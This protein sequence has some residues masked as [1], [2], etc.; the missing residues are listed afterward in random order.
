[1]LSEIRIPAD[2]RVGCLFDSWYL[3]S[4]II[5]IITNKRWHWYSRCRS[6][7]KVR[8]QGEKRAWNKTEQVR[9]YAKTID[10][11]NLKYHSSRKHRA[12]VG[13]Q[14]I[15]E[16]KNLG[17]LKMVFTSLVESG[18]ERIAYFC[19][20]D[21]SIQLIELVKLFELRWKIEIYFR[22]SR[23]FF[24]LEKWYCRNVAS[25]VHH[26][27]LSMLAAVA[28]AWVRMH[29]CE[30]NESFGSLGEFI[31]SCRK[32]NQRELLGIF[33]ER[34]DLEN[35]HSKNSNKFIALCEE[36]GL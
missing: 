22:E 28:C 9:E 4:T 5:E 34:C 13:H 36:M 1:M 14:R 32:R 8:W 20:N 19:T 21:T 31:E 15:G 17:R 7:R 35:I 11:Q 30:K 26:L 12:V 27:C 24:A 6:N 18:S 2:Y 3:N 10:W 29:E 16:L 25:V 33:I 23:K